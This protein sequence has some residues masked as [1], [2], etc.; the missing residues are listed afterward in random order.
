M[1][2]VLKHFNY[3]HSIPELGF[4]EFKTADYIATALEK[5]GYQVTRNVGGTTGIVAILDSGVEG[6]TL[7]IRA[8]MDALGHVIDGK[9][10]VRHTCGHDAHSSTLLTAAEELITEKTVKKGRLKLIFQPAEELGKGAP[11][12][13]KAGVIDDVDYLLGMHIRPQ[14]ECHTGQIIA[15]MYYSASSTIIAEIKGAPAHGARPHLGVNALD[16]AAI[17]IN[18][19]NAIKMDP[20]ASYSAK[21]TR[22][23]CD[24]GVTNAIPALA[25]VTWDV[26]SS[27]NS[28]M[29][30]LTKKI[31]TAIEN[32]ALAIGAKAEIKIEKSIPAAE[33]STELT[34]LVK[35]VIVTEFGEKAL[36][37]EFHTPGGEDFFFYTK[38]KPSLKATYLGL[39]TNARPGLHH[40]DMHFDHEALETG[41]KIHKAMV[42][43]ILG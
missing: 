27:K 38:A 36:I 20:N 5:A 3:L 17:A 16:A 26:R 32:S 33:I 14:Q 23:H 40:P 25:T 35:D 7:G 22:L 2:K 41:V 9:A 4:E 28:I 1:S 37:P 24:S 30:E 8:D 42:K 19:V 12:L 18:S 10:C 43:K 21:A 39:G 31:F 13:I 6:P 11:A 29:D 15:A 34:S